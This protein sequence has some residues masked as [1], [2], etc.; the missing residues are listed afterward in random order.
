MPG[1]Q[2]KRPIQQVLQDAANASIQQTNAN[3]PAAKNPRTLPP[4]SKLGAGSFG[5]AY[6]LAIINFIVR[7]YFV[8]G[9]LFDANREVAM[10]L[11]LPPG[12]YFIPLT[13]NIVGI[14]DKSYYLE[15]PY[16]PDTM[17]LHVAIEQKRIGNLQEVTIGDLILAFQLM[18]DNGLM[19]RDVKA[20]NVLV[21][22]NGHIKLI[23]FGFAAKENEVSKWLGTPEFTAPE[24]IAEFMDRDEVRAVK[25]A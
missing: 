21:Q 14:E 20:N 4:P 8:N 15:M 16:V 1:N 11:L 6:K 12:P 5:E 9:R 25:S 23:D 19:H 10:N 17:D 7:K 13:T 2:R 18:H 3:P 24:V 22:S